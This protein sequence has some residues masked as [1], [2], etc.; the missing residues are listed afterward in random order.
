MDTDYWLELE[1]TYTARIKQ[2]QQLWATE[3]KAVL[4]ELPGSELAC[5]E[6][7]EMVIQF[8]T[9]RYPKQFTLDGTILVNHI[10]GTRSD[11]AS[12]SALEVL[13][14]HVPEDFAIMLRD[15]R[16]GYYILRAGIICSAIGWTLAEKMGKG[17]S[18]IHGLVPDY[19][20][21]MELSMERYVL[22][23]YS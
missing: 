12:T 20:S 6:L 2:R 15:P 7:S 23:K 8:L 11:L 5:K 1:N 4:H 9:A 17:L 19:K 16:T 10:L 14:N 3:S 21:K 18:E 13:L 22:V